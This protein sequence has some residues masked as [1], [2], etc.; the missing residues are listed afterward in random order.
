MNREMIKQ[1]FA[2]IQD[3]QFDPKRPEFFV[4][5]FR[6]CHDEVAPGLKLVPGTVLGFV[7][8]ILTNKNLKKQYK[9]LLLH[10]LFI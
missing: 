8:F 5:D 1:Y 3:Y 7:L 9:E 4:C 6:S 10:V 2:K